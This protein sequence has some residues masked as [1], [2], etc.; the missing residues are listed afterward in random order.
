MNIPI[1]DSHQHFWKFD[2]VRD[3]WINERMAVLQ[4]DFL[5][6]DLDAMLRENGIAGTLTIQSSQTEEENLFHIQ[7]AAHFP[8]I[9]GIVG[10]TDLCHPRLEEALNHY[11]Q[12]PILKGFRHVL[13]SESQRD[14]MLSPAFMKGISQLSKFGYTY[15]ILVF[16]DQL[17]FTKQFVR[18]FPGQPFVIDH[19][20]KPPIQSQSLEPWASEIKEIARQ[21]H[22][23][24]KISGL[25][26]EDDWQH[27]E[28][29]DFT[30]Y[31][32]H[33][34][35]CF[36]TQRIMFG[37]DWPVC[38]LAASYKE[39]KSI[40]EDYFQGF[41]HEEREAIFSKNAIQFYGL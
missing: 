30:P 23:Y 11:K 19:I 14:F 34:V 35:D 22:V 32:D 5:P 27:W 40:A 25:V 26:T 3:S 17:T 10:W 12:Y 13:Q 39:V 38:L 18:A 33:I 16:P 37:S 31:L 8:F 20:A 15:D 4:R 2:P 7:N 1:I 36:G 24:C 29:R 9:K 28:K 41:S 21:E 6:D